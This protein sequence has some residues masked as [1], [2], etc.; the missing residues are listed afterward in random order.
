MMP[1]WIPGVTNALEGRFPLQCLEA[2]GE[3]IGGDEAEYVG[4]QAFDV[5]VVECSDRCFLD[6]AVHPLG[7]TIGPGVIRLRQSVLDS[8]LKTDAVKDVWPEES[9]GGSLAVLWQIG[10]SHAVVG[11]DLMYLI[12]EGCD[13]VPEEGGTF[14]FA[15]VLVE[16]DVG[17]LRDAVDGEEQDEFAVS[18]AQFTAVDMDVSNIVSFEPLALLPGLARWQARD[19][20]AL[21]TTVQRA[22]AQVW[23]GVLQTAENV[24]QWQK[25][26]APEFDDDRFLGRAQDRAFWLRPHGRIGRLDTAAPFQDGFDVEAVLAGEETGWRFRRFELGSNSRRRAGAAVKNACHSASSS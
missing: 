10:E 24:I 25:C 5:L 3:V 7:L 20:M 1:G 19:A 6:G 14:H 22:S 26:P 13:D 23:D 15:G 17:K 18:V 11:E 9:S 16:L 12:G 4:F 21:E 8:V 2:F